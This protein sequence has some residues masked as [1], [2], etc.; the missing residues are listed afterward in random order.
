M[1]ETCVCS[2]TGNLV[3]CMGLSFKAQWQWNKLNLS[4]KL[5]IPNILVVCV[6]ILLDTARSLI[7]TEEL[8]KLSKRVFFFPAEVIRWCWALPCSNCQTRPLIFVSSLYFS[9]FLLSR[10]RPWEPEDGFGRGEWPG[11]RDFLWWGAVSHGCLSEEQREQAHLCRGGICLSDFSEFLL[12][13]L[14]F[15]LFKLRICCGIWVTD[16]S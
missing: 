5:I 2:G 8:V 9:F 16:C 6:Y 3:W 10:Y 15:P 13:L 1:Y 11:V 7:R 12:S 4:V 14:F